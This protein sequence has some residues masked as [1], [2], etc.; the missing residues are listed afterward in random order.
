MTSAINTQLKLL[1]VD[2]EP[3]VLDLAVRLLKKMGFDKI[4]TASNGQNA[5]A[6]LVASQPPIDVIICDLNMPKMDG[7]E[8]IRHAKSAEFSG[9]IIFLSGEDTRILETAQNLGTTQKLNILGTLQKP[10]NPEL[11]KELIAKNSP[12]AAVKK[13]FTSQAPI[14]EEE[15]K[16]GIRSPHSK[17]LLLVYQPKINIKNGEISGVETLARWNHS[18]R[19]ILGPATF[20]PL[21][22]DVG[23]IDE[24]TN[25]IFRKAVEQASKWSADGLDFK[26]SVNFSINSFASEVFSNFI[27]D[28]TE[29]FGL[30]PSRLILEVTETQVMEHSVDCVEFLTR[31]RMKKFG[32]SID[33]F[34]TGNSSMQQLKSIPF[35]E[36]KIDRAFVHK[37]ATNSSA[38]A[39]LE[40]S[41]ILAKNLN[42]QTVAEG[43]ETREDWD[44][45]KSLDVDYMQ[46]F[47]CAKPMADAELREFIIN[48]K[49][50]H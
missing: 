13:T 28:T 45:V 38:K 5:L 3:F 8:F 37:A 7:I 48:W 36:L 22:E 6:I 19:G 50:P 15:L 1:V 39:I 4:T 47:Y 21:A 29:E 41:V 34:G 25:S 27:I 12:D 20:I 35:S 40:A 46:G 9:G 49:G 14:S 33:D 17:E 26:I 2:D 10:L 42:M 18:D 43:G 23:L 24:L 44:L 32:L 31:L 30:D 11:L 16:R